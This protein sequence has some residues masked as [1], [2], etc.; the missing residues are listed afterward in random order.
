MLREAATGTKAYLDS[1]GGRGDFY[2]GEGMLIVD[3]LLVTG[4]LVA[5]RRAFRDRA[6][7]LLWITTALFVLGLA[8][9][10]ADGDVVGGRVGS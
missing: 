4:L 5:K 2:P 10:T 8:L 1:F 6:R 9:A 7:P 3:S